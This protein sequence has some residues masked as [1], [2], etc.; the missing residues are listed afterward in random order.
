MNNL[1]VIEREQLKF[2]RTSKG[3]CAF[4]AVAAK[5][6]GKYGW[7]QVITDAHSDSID[8]EIQRAIHTPDVTTLSLIFP[9]VTTDEDL[10]SFVEILRNCRNVFFEHETV[11]EDTICFGI[12]VKVGDLKSWV[13]GFGNY[14]FLPETRR[15]PYTEITFRVKPRPNYKWV[16]KKSPA[17]V[18]HLADLDMLGIT[19]ATFIRLWEL[20]LQNTA[21]RLGHKPDLKSAAK[22]TYSIPCGF[23]ESHC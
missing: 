15:T 14:G 1:D 4:A 6:P 5:D 13:S 12:R 19:K 8:T 7:H 3:G 16:M 23:Y 17:N 9:S 18:I 10:I 2:Y 11:Y 20:S 21:K 22:T